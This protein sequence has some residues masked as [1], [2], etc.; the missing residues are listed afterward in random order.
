MA[1]DLAARASLLVLQ[2]VRLAGVAGLVTTAL[3][4]S[5]NS[6]HPERRFRP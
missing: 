1:A 3:A 4:T 5:V 2:G 6:P